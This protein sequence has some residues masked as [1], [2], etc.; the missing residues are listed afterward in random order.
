MNYSE[1]KEL[2]KNEERLSFEGWDFSHLENRME[3][4]KLPW[5]Y[6]SIVEKYLKKEYKI[7]DMG[8]GGGEFL[9]TLKHPY[10]KT[11]VTEKWEP[12]VK[13]CKEKLEPLGIEVKNVVKDEELPF[14]DS[15]FDMILNRHESYDVKELKRILKPNGIFVTQQVGGENNN[16][17]SNKLIKDFKPKFTDNKLDN[18]FN[19][20]KNNK[21]EIL[22]KNEYFPY[23]RFL[24]VGAVVYYC[25]VIEWEFPNF[26]VE[27]SFNELCEIYEEIQKN[28]YYETLG[29]RFIIVAKNIK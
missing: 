15:S 22:Y 3:E 25:K 28:K 12:N 24:D 23:M 6:K 26:S 18:A 21:F 4:E 10:E 14:E 13:L 16:I 8:T 17:L 11:S 19:S 27:D 20:L 2:L 1:L 7:L 29:H 9:L 5:D